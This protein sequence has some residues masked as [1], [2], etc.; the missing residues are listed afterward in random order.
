[1]INWP[2]PLWFPLVPRISSTKCRDS[3]LSWTLGAFLGKTSGPRSLADQRKNTCGG[4][5]AKLRTSARVS[6]SGTQDAGILG[7]LLK[8][9]V[10]SR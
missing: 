4:S 8:W 2:C 7:N 1:M 3:Q 5:P 10:G 9:L 6:S